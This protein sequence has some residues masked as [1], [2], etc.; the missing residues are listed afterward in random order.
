VKK[1][2]FLFF[3]FFVITTSC[4][5]AA[6]AQGS[7]TP[8]ENGWYPIDTAPSAVGDFERELAVRQHY[9]VR[10]TKC[11]AGLP[12]EL[13]ERLPT[14]GFVVSVYDPIHGGTR[15]TGLTE[16]EMQRTDAV[17]VVLYGTTTAEQGLLPSSFQYR[18]EWG[19]IF[20]PAVRMDDN[21]FCAVFAHE[22]F[23]AQHAQGDA[24][25][26]E[27]E[28]LTEEVRAHELERTI[29]DWQTRGAYRSALLLA[30]EGETRM[31]FMSLFEK[32]QTVDSLFPPAQ[33]EV[34]Q[35]IRYAQIYLDLMFVRL[36][37]TYCVSEQAKVDLYRTILRSSQEGR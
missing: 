2:L 27:Y 20:V 12:Q 10:V 5:K 1:Q 7:V 32:I 34:E 8:S 24:T 4:S 26:S 30:I 36:E 23:H 14:G 21:W 3:L 13:R 16:A 25:K 33:S 29:L 18:P 19:A 11:L 17:E 22:L 37:P 35:N 15:M 9:A 31:D 6:G 28:L